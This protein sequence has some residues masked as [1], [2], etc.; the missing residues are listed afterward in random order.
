MKH[1]FISHAD[2]NEAFNSAS[3]EEVEKFFKLMDTVAKKHGFE[4]VFWGN[5]W[6]VLESLTFVCKSDKS[7]D[8]YIAFRQAFGR[9]LAEKKMPPYFSKTRTITVTR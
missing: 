8:G 6:G 4:L 7:L 2:V 5:P 1:L 3:S 9:E